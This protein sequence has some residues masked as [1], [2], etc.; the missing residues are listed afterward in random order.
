MTFVLGLLPTASDAESAVNNLTEEGFSERSISVVL[1]RAADARAIIADG[2]PLRGATGGDLAGR[3]S[4][5]GVPPPEAEQYAAGVQGGQALLA[6]SAGG[7]AAEAA[8]ETL[9]SYQAQRLQVVES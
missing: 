5:L 8:K 2:G 4:A 9:Q 6:I 7:D 3:L 1:E